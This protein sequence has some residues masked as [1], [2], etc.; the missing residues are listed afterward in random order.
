[1]SESAQVQSNATR[2]L[3]ADRH[4]LAQ[5]EKWMAMIRELAHE[6]QGQTKLHG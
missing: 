5:V 6:R 4:A 3:E 1:M 2:R